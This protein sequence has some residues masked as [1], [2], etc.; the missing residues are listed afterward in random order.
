MSRSSANLTLFRKGLKN[1]TCHSQIPLRPQKDSAE[2]S[3]RVVLALGMV[4]SGWHILGDA[5]RQRFPLCITVCT[6]VPGVTPSYGQMSPATMDTLPTP[7]PSPQIC[8]H[9]FLELVQ[10]IKSPDGDK[11]KVMLLPQCYLRPRGALTV[12][13]MN[14]PKRRDSATVLTSALRR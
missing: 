9:G 4:R 11:T 8:L 6:H 7:T 10:W 2:W 13:T 1:H 14:P 5:S 3:R 12:G